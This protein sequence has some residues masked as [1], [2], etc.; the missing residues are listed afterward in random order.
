[1]QMENR[2]VQPRFMLAA[3]ASGSG[4]TLITCGILQALKNRGLAVSAFKCGPDY[5][6]PMFHERVLKTKS[7]NLDTFFTDEETTRYLFWKNAAGTD[8]SVME[9]VMGYY[10]G[11][12]GIS[13]QASAYDLARVTDTPVVLV[14]DT[15]GMSLSVLAY[16]KGFLTYRE[17]SGIRGV[18]LN[19]MSAMLYPQV[20]RMIE[21]ELGVRVFG[22]VPK[23]EDCVIES[24]HLG[25]VLPG[26]V[27]ALEEKLKKLAGILEGSLDLDALLELAGTA[28]EQKAADGRRYAL[29]ERGRKG[30]P[31]RIALARDEAFC[32]IYEDNL[33]LLRELGAQ[34]TE[35]SPIHDTQLPKGVGG[36]LLYGGYPELYAK[37]LS[38]N[39]AM[40]R[41]IREAVEGGIPVMAECGGF[42]YLH[43][44]MEDME[45]NAYPMAGVIDGE[46]YRTR[47]LGRFGYIELEAI[48][49]NT[50][51]A[52]QE[53]RLR[54]H[55]FHYF[56][57]TSCGEAYLARKPLRKRSWK[58][59]H[60]TETML[61][62]FPHLYYY[63]NPHL[64]AEFVEKCRAYKNMG[65]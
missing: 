24:R 54:G 21:A 31:V 9:G 33:Q 18:I 7:R 42:M 41:A 14:V 29:E 48:A 30:E 3:G 53:E 23:V 39:T 49:E 17:D 47:T 56:D 45:G 59:I 8:I 26:E 51:E 28:G 5:I 20:K 15:K 34:F 35:F 22:Y 12:G 64:A 43:R 46:A 27:E 32:F 65:D 10:D 62:G 19:R 55:E 6:D 61:A 40:R 13:E 16:L 58:C 63:S 38:A 60:K 57:S 2:K 37:E 52:A 50:K 25:L 1:M 4:K 36:M 11:L 44:S